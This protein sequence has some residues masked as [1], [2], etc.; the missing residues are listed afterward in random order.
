MHHV[1]FVPGVG[2]ARNKLAECGLRTH[3][4]EGVT[5]GQEIEE[6]RFAPNEQQGIVIQWSPDG[7]M[8]LDFDAI[9]WTP[10]VAV[11]GREA[12]RYWVGVIPDSL[13]APPELAKQTCVP[14]R[15]V[16]LNERRWCIPSLSQLPIA[17]QATDNGWG[18]VVPPELATYWDLCGSVREQ[19]EQAEGGEVFDA[20][21]ACDLVTMALN[22]NYRMPRELVGVLGLLTSGESGTLLAASYAALWDRPEAVAAIPVSR[23]REGGA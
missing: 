18:F 16:Q 7:P 12:E 10:A 1:V 3:F 15:F 8:A 13:P 20:A 6:R 19:L 23:L 22:I 4:I 2:P 17:Y 14:G 11:E 21:D 9:E 5:T